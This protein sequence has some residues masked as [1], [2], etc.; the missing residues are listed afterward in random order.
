MAELLSHADTEGLRRW[1]S[2]SLGYPDQPGSEW[3]REQIASGYN[4]LG[5]ADI[6]VLAPAEGIYLAMRALL[7]P[8][9]HVVATVPNY[10]SLTEVARSI[11][12]EVSDWQ[13][14]WTGPVATPHFA[15]GRLKDLL[16]TGTKLVIANWPH[17]PTGALPSAADM[18]EIIALCDAAGAHLFVDE[19]YRGLEHGGA[20][21][22][23]RAVCDA[24]PRGVSLAGVSKTFGL[25]GLRIGW[26]ASLDRS[27]MSR[28]A[29]LKDYTTICPPAPSEALAFIALR[30]HQPLL[31]RN[32]AIVGHGLNAC[33]AHVLAQSEFL[34]WSEPAAGTFAFVRLRRGSTGCVSASAYCDALRQRANLMLLPSSLFACGDDR[35]RL[36]FGHERVPR[37]LGRWANDL[38]THGLA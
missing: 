33:R 31:A 30:A 11:G 37:L 5:A 29:E 34:E 1:D 32:R 16:R 38:S 24:Y 21:T 8:G 36:T 9:D 13:V 10:Q 12:C 18:S 27:F 22:R 3:L 2:L 25:P 15:P 7:S 6:N 14:E 35:V 26:L 4:M 28:V 19:M 23:L 20:S 17:N